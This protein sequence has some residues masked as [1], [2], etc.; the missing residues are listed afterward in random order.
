[1][2]K[3]FNSSSTK[4][5]FTIVEVS[6]AMA[7]IAALLITIALTI[8]GIMTTFQK[9]VTLKSVNNVGRNLISEFTTAI[10]TAPSIDSTSLCNVYATGNVDDCIRDGAF[11]YI[12]QE[13]VGTTVDTATGVTSPQGVQYFGLL[14]TGKYTYAWNTYHGIE[15]KQYLTI[16]YKTSTSG[17]TLSVPA[18]PDPADKKTYFRLIRFEDTTYNACAQNVDSSYNIKPEF[19]STSYPNPVIN[20][21]TLANGVP[22]KI[23]TPQDGYLES[24]E[25]D[26][27]LDLYEFVIFPISQ[28]VVTLRS[29][30]S[31]TFILATNNGDVNITR[32]G[33]Y[34]DPKAA[35][36]EEGQT[37]SQLNLGS[38]FSY[39]GINKFNFAAR[40]AGSGI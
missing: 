10:N 11:K 18:S 38:G 19:S 39:C 13:R 34:C 8:S 21:T 15:N 23:A 24:S 12:F 1:M 6:L 33:D 36:Y 29:F 35:G 2:K 32:T 16:N 26:V 30:F 5:G 17:P 22:T 28:D 27:N 31:G 40:T 9:G 25:S 20:M 37:S 4:S 3:N 7:F 14:C